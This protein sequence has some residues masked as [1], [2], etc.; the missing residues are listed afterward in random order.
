MFVAILSESIDLMIVAYNHSNGTQE[1]PSSILCLMEWIYSDNYLSLLSNIY[2]NNQVSVISLSWTHLLSLLFRITANVPD[3][4]LGP[5]GVRLLLLFRGFIGSVFSGRSIVQ[6]WLTFPL[7]F[8]GLFGVYFSLQYLSLSDAT[9]LTFLVPMCT[10][11]AGALFLGEKISYRE[12]SAGRKWN[13]FRFQK[14]HTSQ[15]C[16]SRQSGGRCSDCTAYRYI[17]LSRPSCTRRCWNR[18]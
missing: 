11:M 13:L 6:F 16:I 17:W 12:A 15:K 10:A 5:K 3:P 18:R 14:K 7:R 1:I 4:I 2:V 9:V 8:F